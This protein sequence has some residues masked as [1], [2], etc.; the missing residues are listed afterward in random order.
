MV[1]YHNYHI[2]GIYIMSSW[3]CFLLTQSSQ[4]EFT[5][6]SDEPPGPPGQL[7]AATLCQWPIAWRPDASMMIS[8]GAPGMVCWTP[9]K[10]PSKACWT[11]PALIG[12]SLKKKGCERLKLPQDWIPYCG[13]LMNINGLYGRSTTC[14]WG[15]VQKFLAVLGF[16]F[17]MLSS[18]SGRKN[19][20]YIVGGISHKNDGS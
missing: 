10:T 4:S 15:F 14:W 11:T 16:I 8:P 6:C 19:G 2:M 17:S 12:K 7:D 1:T 13:S 18:N 9:K 20:V 3:G 5:V